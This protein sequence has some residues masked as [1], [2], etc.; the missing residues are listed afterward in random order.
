MR[1]S[2]ATKFIAV[3]LCALSIVAIAASGLGI[4]FMESYNL[5]NEP[6]ETQ[7]TARLDSLAEEAA[8]YHAQLHAAHRHAAQADHLK[9]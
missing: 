9:P 3:L 4:L 6:L 7:K 1:Y 8:W 5:F 2:V